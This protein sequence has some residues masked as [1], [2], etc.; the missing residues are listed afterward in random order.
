MIVLSAELQTRP[1]F[2]ILMETIGLESLSNSFKSLKKKKIDPT[3]P[4]PQSK[5]ATNR[6]K[7]STS[8]KKYPQNSTNCKKS[9]KSMARKQKNISTAN[10]IKEANMATQYEENGFIFDLA[11][12][13]TC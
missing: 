7:L 6:N 2:Q 13:P 8:E 3:K 10:K 12:T 11:T 1:L 4:S 9:K 5:R